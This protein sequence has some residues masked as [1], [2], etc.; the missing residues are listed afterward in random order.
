[1]KSRVAVRPITSAPVFLPSLLTPTC[2]VPIS[3]PIFHPCYSCCCPTVA[4][5]HEH[6]DTHVRVHTYTNTSTHAQ[7]RARTQLLFHQFCFHH[8]ITGPGQLA[9][10]TI[11]RRRETGAAVRGN[12]SRASFIAAR[13]RRREE[14]EGSGPKIDS[15]AIKSHGEI[16]HLHICIINSWA[17]PCLSL[18]PSRASVA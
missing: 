3:S 18:R 6:T 15:D 9:P 14:K 2:G 11:L 8:F 13:E 16:I 4:S 17:A 7:T 10:G 5:S 1:M 12:G